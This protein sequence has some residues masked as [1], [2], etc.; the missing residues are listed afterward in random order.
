MVFFCDVGLL[1]LLLIITAAV[2]I[3]NSVT[4]RD[5]TKRPTWIQYVDATYAVCIIS[6]QDGQ[7]SM[8]LTTLLRC[9]NAQWKR[10]QCISSS[11]PLKNFLAATGTPSALQAPCG[12]IHLSNTIEASS[13]MRQWRITV[14]SQLY[15]NLTFQELVLSMPHGRCDLLLG[16][17]YLTIHPVFYSLDL[18]AKD[19]VFLCGE[20]S[21]F[22]M[23]WRGSRALLRYRRVPSITRIGHCRI[24]YQVC[25]QRVRIPKVHIIH[26]VSVLQGANS[27]L[28]KL[29][30]VPFFE[31]GPEHVMYAIHLLG[32]KLR[33]LNMMFVL[34]DARKYFS[35]DIFDGPG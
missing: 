20:H 34:T 23:V 16:P 4:P 31:S 29:S 27:T 6:H 15:L 30:E 17:E 3:S 24:Q 22:S 13:P 5:E 19:A 9:F 11:Q 33:L 14:H 10:L 28:L 21:P 2:P 26:R 32:N 18:S 12:L 25:D 8:K 1:R 7:V 35:V